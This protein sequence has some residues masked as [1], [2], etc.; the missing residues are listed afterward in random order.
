MYGLG[1]KGVVVTSNVAEIQ[2]CLKAVNIAKQ[3]G[4]T[5]LNI[6]TD[7]LLVVECMTKRL[8]AR[9]KNLWQWKWI[10]GRI[11]KEKKIVRKLA[12]ASE[13]MKIKFVSFGF[14]E[15]NR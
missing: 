11:A 10:F 4:V 14:Y 6:H 2:A 1:V 13:N 3:N 12:A 5:K 7:A 15:M 9:S 8:C